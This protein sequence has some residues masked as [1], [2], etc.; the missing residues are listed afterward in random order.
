[1]KD[2]IIGG[3]YSTHGINRMG[4]CVGGG[5]INKEEFDLKTHARSWLVRPNRSWQDNIK[6]TLRGRREGLDFKS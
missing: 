3:T 2:G 1:M 4:V 6:W 5:R